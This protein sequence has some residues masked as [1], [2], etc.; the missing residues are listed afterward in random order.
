VALTLISVTACT[1]G[2][3]EA[4]AF[5]AAAE[6]HKSDYV[7]LA[8][9][10]TPD[11]Y[12]AEMDADSDARISSLAAMWSDLEEAAPEE[13][14]SEVVSMSIQWRDLSA[15]IEGTQQ[16]AEVEAYYFTT[17]KDYL[18]QNCG[19]SYAVAANE[20]ASIATA[21][22]AE[23]ES[24]IE[25]E[26]SLYLEDAW[27]TEKGYSYRVSF[28]YFGPTVTPDTLNALPGETDLAYRFDFGGTLWNQL[29]DRNAP[30]FEGLMRMTPF[31]GID[32][33]VC[34]ALDDG[35][36]DIVDRT[37]DSYCT[38]GYVDALSGLSSVDAGS[39]VDL[40][41]EGAA[42]LTVPEEDA[43]SVTKELKSPLFWAFSRDGGTIEDDACKVPVTSS[44]W[45]YTASTKP[46]DCDGL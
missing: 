2:N 12:Y 11:L 38:V 14:S 36:G 43:D 1:S 42:D 13:I 15:G 10:A 31:W 29:D 30:T 39:L 8:S 27:K 32:S 19:S 37:A 35:R 16:N 44:G 3:S 45:Y 41:G 7:S 21:E 24:E 9:S 18:A 33:G 25:P 20:N 46:F 40:T 26:H 5:C 22:P 17:V 4:Q 6:K 28:H 23:S 34:K